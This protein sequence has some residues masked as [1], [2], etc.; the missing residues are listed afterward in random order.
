MDKK[1]IMSVAYCGLYCPLC[2]KMR[3]AEAAEKLKRELDAAKAKDASFLEDNP[4]LKPS[5]D[6][7]VG[8]R[9]LK[10]CREGGGKPNCRIKKC[11]EDKKYVGCWECLD[12]ERCDKLKAQFVSNIKQ[13][14]ESGIDCFIAK[15]NRQ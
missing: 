14:R 10:F 13:I 11:C 4:G 12:Y 15:N 1:G 6:S 3:V 5:L 9:C 2:Y 8:L 7:L